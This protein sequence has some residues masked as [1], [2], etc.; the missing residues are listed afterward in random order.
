MKSA[1]EHALHHLFTLL[2]I[3][4]PAIRDQPSPLFAER[5]ALYFSAL[6][7]I[8]GVH[9]T[10]FP[11]W[12]HWRGLSPEEIGLIGAVPIF[13]RT[14]LTPWIAAWADTHNQHRQLII[15][16]SAASAVLS[17]IVGRCET[18]W[19]IAIAAMPFAI[20]I[21]MVMPLTET[22][23]VSGVRS[24]GH[25][26]GRM[27]LWGSAMFLVTVLLTGTWVDVS[28]PSIIST[29]L[30]AA[31]VLTASVAL[32]LPKP[33]ASA[34]PVGVQ[35]PATERGLIAALL[36]QPVFFL[37]LIAV[38]AGMGS[39]AAFYTFGA[40]HLKTLGISGTA[41]GALW[42]I[43]ILAEMALL[44]VSAPLVA[45]FGPVRLLMA[46]AA[47]AVVRWGAMSLDPPFE[48][49]ILLQLLHAATYGATHIGAIHFIARTVPTRGA[50]T[51]QA[52]YSAIGA[53]LVTGTATIIAGQSYPML[54]GKTFLLMSV[55]AGVGLVAAIAIE[56]I[57]SGGPVLTNPA[58]TDAITSGS[59]ELPVPTAV[60]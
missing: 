2:A 26:Y 53:G 20:A 17:L 40:L 46:G 19:P 49:L 4:K 3:S 28:G 39:H 57:W 34:L 33:T 14:L 44:A 18:F 27:R 52:L 47:S 1:L 11:V 54:G 8:Y 50:G 24:A 48:M 42:T 23:A 58:V 51:A 59:E 5:M 12:L 32:L 25:D 36:T 13:A 55:L 15:W 6:F 60:A 21:A 35:R 29:I 37:F 16:L 56:K 7:L 30:C 43:S 10:Y 45:K 41:F 38:G 22:V 9:I 31:S